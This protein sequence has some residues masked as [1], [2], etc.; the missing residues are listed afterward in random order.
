MTE[1]LGYFKYSHFQQERDTGTNL[2]EVVS[3]VSTAF[4]LSNIPSFINAASISSFFTKLRKI[5]N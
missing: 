5:V 4:T 2:L 1:L 3:Q